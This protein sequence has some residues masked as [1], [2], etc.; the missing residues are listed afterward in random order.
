MLSAGRMDEFQR[1]M[2]IQAMNEMDYAAETQMFI[3]DAGI[4]PI[5]ALTS[6]Y[7]KIDDAVGPSGLL[8]AHGQ[9]ETVHEIPWG[10]LMQRQ[11]RAPYWRALY[12]MDERSLT[13]VRQLGSPRRKPALE[14]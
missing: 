6:T 3:G 8:R 14:H 1:L 2:L 9:N 7:V 11:F 13:D 10:D 5:Q 12:A 4:C